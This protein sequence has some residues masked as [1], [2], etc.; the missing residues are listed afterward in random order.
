MQTSGA[1]GAT[2][3][4][5]RAG[6][7]QD[8]NIS[9]RT[10]SMIMMNRYIA[11]SFRRARHDARMTRHVAESMMRLK[12]WIN[13][14]LICCINTACRRYSYHRCTIFGT[15]PPFWNLE[16]CCNRKYT[17]TITPFRG[18]S[19]ARTSATHET[20]RPVHSRC[21]KGCWT[22]QSRLWLL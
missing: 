2:P 14:Q 1:Q 16:S 3:P 10:H 21:H 20:R 11:G 7:R 22:Y 6:P 13:C 18:I 19:A 5:D 15:V 4:S 17:S 12:Y 8:V 9:M